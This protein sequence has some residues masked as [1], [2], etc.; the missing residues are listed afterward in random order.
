[1]SNLLKSN[2]W[3][4]IWMLQI[5]KIKIKEGGPN[6]WPVWRIGSHQANSSPLFNLRKFQ[7]IEKST[8]EQIE[9]HLSAMNDKEF[10]S[11]KFLE[12]K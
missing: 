6:N 5:S 1:M 8:G 10:E 9:T 2:E 7:K 4:R 12:L 3:E 11:L